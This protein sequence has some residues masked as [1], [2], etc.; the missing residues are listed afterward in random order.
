MLREEML[1]ARE[2]SEKARSLAIPERRDELVG[3][4]L[5]CRQLRE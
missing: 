4:K 5:E 2:V 3:A 1:A